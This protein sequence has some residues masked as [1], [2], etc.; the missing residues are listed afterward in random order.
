MA[1]Q[2]RWLPV[3]AGVVVVLGGALVWQ[4]FHQQIISTVGGGVASLIT[5]V[6]S[7]QGTVAS[8]APAPAMPGSPAGSPVAS[9]ATT[10]APQAVRFYSATGR[11]VSCSNSVLVITRG[12]EGRLSFA[13]TQDSKADCVRNVGRVVRVEYTQ[14]GA[15]KIVNRIVI[16]A[17]EQRKAGAR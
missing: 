8:G 1:K 2:T 15:R 10:A 9:P 7:G 14:T 12:E 4:H 16:P 13:I 17:Q 11:V 5:R 3:C 6:R